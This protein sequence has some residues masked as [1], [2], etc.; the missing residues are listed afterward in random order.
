MSST[1]LYLCRQPVP[2]HAPTTRLPSIS[3]V[4]ATHLWSTSGAG[5]GDTQKQG[6]LTSATE[7]GSPKVTALPW[8]VC[9]GRGLNP[10]QGHQSPG[11][12]Q[13]CSQDCY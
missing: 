8:L 2:G 12:Q 7:R 13:W 10:A 5:R 9:R 1:I 4:P 11:G 6:T 3:F